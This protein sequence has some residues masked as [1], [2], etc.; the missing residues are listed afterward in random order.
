MSLEATRWAWDQFQQLPQLKPSS[1]LVLLCLADRANGGHVCWPSIE[2]ITI[3]TGLDKSTVI[4]SIKIL[5]EAGLLDRKK[6]FGTSPI[7]QLAIN[8]GPATIPEKQNSENTENCHSIPENKNSSFSTCSIRESPP[9]VL[10]LPGKEPVIE[11]IIEPI[12]EPVSKPTSSKCGK[13]AVG[14]KTFLDHCK[15]NHE[16]AMPETDSVFEY[17]DA[18]GIPNEFLYL[19][20]REFV[21][22]N[23]EREKR[24]RDWRKVFRKCVRENWY[25][26]WWFDGN[27]CLLTT[28]GKQAERA[29]SQ[30]AAA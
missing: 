19:C 12:I 22:R 24:Y 9:P 18:V 23:R 1:R 8:S 11:P 30:S 3:D 14:I 16:A 27:Q 17:A 4:T 20:W 6:R 2:Q 5:L 28:A 7:Y 26:L 21:D 10:R 15:E 13:S 25:K 29:H